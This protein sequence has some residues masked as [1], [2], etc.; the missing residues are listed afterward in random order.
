MRR[1]DISEE[2]YKKCYQEYMEGKEDK[3]SS[4]PSLSNA[5]EIEKKFINDLKKKT[6]W[7]KK[8]EHVMLYYVGV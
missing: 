8:M 3:F 5:V 1:F 6:L 4:I 7:N 2:M